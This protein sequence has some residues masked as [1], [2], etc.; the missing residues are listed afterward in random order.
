V[1]KKARDK[2]SQD[3]PILDELTIKD[4]LLA[5]LARLRPMK[6]YGQDFRTAAMHVFCTL[7]PGE[8]TPNSV[9]ELAQILMECKDRLCEWRESAARAGADEALSFV[10]SWYEGITLECLQSM[11]SGSKWT[12]DPELVR[13]RQ[14]RAYSI[15]RYAST[16]TFIPDPEEA[17]EEEEEAVDPDAGTSEAG[18][19]SPP[20]DPA[21]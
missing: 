6:T 8:D 12:T 1:V 16:H 20:N 5:I 17:A 14:Q 21:I 13:E 11:R 18:I 7:W 19:A 3:G 15:A 2:R 10:L 9:E 4:H